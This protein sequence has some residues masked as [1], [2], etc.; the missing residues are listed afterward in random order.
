LK[1]QFGAFVL[2]L[3]LLVQ[4]AASTCKDFLFP[5][6]HFILHSAVVPYLVPNRV[7]VAYTDT[8]NVANEEQF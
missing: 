2:V 6:K 1:S 7:S 8:M 3:F 5:A 4:P